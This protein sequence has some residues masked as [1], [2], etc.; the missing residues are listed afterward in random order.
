[1]ELENKELCKKCG[2]YCCKKS[3]CDYFPRDFESLTTKAIL[4]IL[5]DG[6]ISIV[7]SLKFRELKNGK[8]IMEPLL[9]LRARNKDRNI[10]DLLSIK[11]PCSL[12]T[13]NGC[14]YDLEHRPS[15]GVNLIPGNSKYECFPKEDVKKLIEGWQ[16]YQ[17][18]L[19][20]V[21]KILTGKEVEEQLK[22]DAE[23]LI[24]DIDSLMK[25]KVEEQIDILGLIPL[26]KRVYPDLKQKQYIKK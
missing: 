14:P 5:K 13:E 9:Y 11:T 15:G 12:L 24:N 26:L 23:I 25:A 10:V 18:P 1:M 20:K 6:N 17:K 19:Y 2:G 8:L 16:S 4:E 22:I 21:V 3:E 7:S